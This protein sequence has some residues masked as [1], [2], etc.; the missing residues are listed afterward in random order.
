M[1]DQRYASPLKVFDTNQ[2]QSLAL[3]GN[4]AAMDR[5]TAQIKTNWQNAEATR[6]ATRSKW[7]YTTDAA[8]EEA[9]RNRE[10][11]IKLKTMDYIFGGKGVNGNSNSKITQEINELFQNMISEDANEETR[12]KTWQK[13]AT[14][15]FDRY[16]K[17]WNDL[18]NAQLQTAL[19][20]YNALRELG[21]PEAEARA[22]A[23]I[24]NRLLKGSACCESYLKAKTTKSYSTML[25]IVKSKT[26]S[27]FMNA[28]RTVTRIRTKMQHGY[29]FSNM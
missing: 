18:P 16:Y 25:I 24:K 22:A 21:Y 5:L 26:G 8:S 6:A 7:E 28:L 1:F 27:A 13:A 20:T 3:L 19:E 14:R 11:T 15:V 23:A 17:G 10:H 2:A 29:L 9:A 4:T 12:K